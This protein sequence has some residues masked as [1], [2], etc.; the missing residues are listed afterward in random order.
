MATSRELLGERRFPRS[1]PSNYPGV[2]MAYFHGNFN[3]SSLD[4]RFVDLPLTGLEP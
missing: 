1:R 4:F 2:E 3:C